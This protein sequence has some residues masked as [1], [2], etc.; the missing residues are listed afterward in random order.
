MIKIR[1]F[2]FAHPLTVIG[3]RYPPARTR[4]ADEQLAQGFPGLGKNKLE[5]N[6]FVE[7]GAGSDMDNFYTQPSYRMPADV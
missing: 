4:G 6:L 1:W 5:I 2:K 7:I 3:D